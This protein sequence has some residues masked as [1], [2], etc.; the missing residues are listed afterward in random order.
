MGFYRSTS[1]K[2]S[3]NRKDEFF[4]FSN[5]SS[6]EIKNYVA[7][8]V[9]T[10]RNPI[11]HTFHQVFGRRLMTFLNIF[12]GRSVRVPKVGLLN[13]YKF[14]VKVYT[15]VDKHDYTEEAY[16]KASAIFDR[17]VDQL[18]VMVERVS[19]VVQ[20]ADCCNRKDSNVTNHLRHVFS[21]EE[22]GYQEED[23]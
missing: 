15:Y 21:K 10:S 6:H 3:T 13:K 20:R 11:Y 23:S 17:R 19:K 18:K 4:D 12:Q 9:G 8:L 1:L 14:F 22:K 7:Y 2:Q 16:E 5:M